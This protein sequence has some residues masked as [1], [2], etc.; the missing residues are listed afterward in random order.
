MC[1]GLDKRSKPRYVEFAMQQE[2]QKAT[3]TA[4]VEELVSRKV[5]RIRQQYGGLANF[6]NL[7][8]ARQKHRGS[9]TP[10]RFHHPL[11]LTHTRKT[12]V[13]ARAK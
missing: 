1:S 4:S 10:M 9:V 13:L 8:E 11:T 5:F 3:L 2:I 7:M 12:S 6:F